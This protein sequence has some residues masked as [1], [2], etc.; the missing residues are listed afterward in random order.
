M[1]E[2]QILFSGP[3]V[4]AI[5]EG[6]KTQTRRPITHFDG[7]TYAL[8]PD[9]VRWQFQ[10]GEDQRASYRNKWWAYPA[11]SGG[12][13]FPVHG[14]RCRYGV[15]GDRLWVRE[16]WRPT[17]I[18]DDM[19]T[20]KITKKFHDPRGAMKGHLVFRADDRPYDSDCSGIWRPS[21]FMPRWACRLVLEVTRVRVERLQ[22]ISESD[23]KAEGVTVYDQD[24]YPAATE[25]GR[26]W[27][28]IDAYHDLWDS[29]NAKR[30]PWAS[31]PRVWVVEFK[32]AQ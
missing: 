28:A 10:D 31:N 23:A 15:E 3:M 11:G 21:I 18:W 17:G 27:G 26:F 24:V 19:T 25:R 4:R 9:Y 5:L 6:R 30:S 20:A 8:N 1:T 32:V 7:S 12:S 2:R 16:T 22:E 14:E 29:L 13:S